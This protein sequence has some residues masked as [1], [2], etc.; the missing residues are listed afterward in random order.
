MSQQ[1]I[2][3]SDMV[4]QKSVGRCGLSHENP[5]LTIP[6]L[7]LAQDIMVSFMSDKISNTIA[8]IN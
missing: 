3:A 1:N 7:L 8:K 4:S 5:K 6:L 2:G